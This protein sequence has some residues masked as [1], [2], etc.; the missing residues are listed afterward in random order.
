MVHIEKEIQKQVLNGGM[1]EV[2]FSRSIPTS[3]VNV[4]RIFK[5]SNIDIKLRQRICLVLEQDFFREI[6]DSEKYLDSWDRAKS[7][8]TNSVTC[9][10]SVIHVSHSNGVF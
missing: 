6:S 10:K 4:Y 8:E 5:R 1:T 9:D 3:L 7:R 2:A